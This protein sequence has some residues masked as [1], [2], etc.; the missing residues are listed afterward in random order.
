MPVTALEIW[1]RDRSLVLKKKN[2]VWKVEV[3]FGE[4][5]Q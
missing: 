1:Q 2:P 5:I 4:D 3:H